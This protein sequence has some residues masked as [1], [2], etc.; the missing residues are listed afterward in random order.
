MNTI[1]TMRCNF[2]E[3]LNIYPIVIAPN[4]DTTLNIFS[5]F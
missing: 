3:L 5:N 4:T 2:D 1:L